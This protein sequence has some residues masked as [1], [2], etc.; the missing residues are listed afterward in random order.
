MDDFQQD[1]AQSRHYPVEENMRWQRREWR[2]QQ[3][4]YALLLAIVVGGACGL[5]SKGFL[6]DRTR[7]SPQGSLEVKYERFAR[8]QSDM[9]MTIRL[10]A[11]RDRLY[12]IT[13]SGDGVDNFQLQSIQPQP[14]RA[15]SSEHSLT[16]WYKTQNI[17]RGASIW[18]GG[19][20]QSPGKYAFTVSDS[21]GAQVDFTQWVY[22]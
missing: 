9:A 20:P 18:L 6:S 4:G 2:I 19:Q 21:S 17:N 22:P 1:E 15:E 14:L 7:V 16:L 5:F 3:L 11:L 10:H 12:S 8:Q 13:L